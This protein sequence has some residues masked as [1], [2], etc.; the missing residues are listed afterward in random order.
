MSFSYRPFLVELF[1]GASL[2]EVHR[3]IVPILVHGPQASLLLRPLLDCGADFT[4]LPLAVATATGIKLDMG[5]AGAVGGIEGGSLVTYPG[6]AALELSD[7]VLSYRWTTTVHFASG[8]N[9][10]LGHMGCL[11]FFTA[12]LDHYHRSFSL[13]PNELYLSRP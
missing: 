9:M 1:D 7:S 8:N 12:T 3:P 5:R 4:L 2:T 13:E 10:L 6:V 11:E